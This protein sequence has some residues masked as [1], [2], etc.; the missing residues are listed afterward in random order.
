[1]RIDADVGADAQTRFE[2]P[3]GELERRAVSEVGARAPI[4]ERDLGQEPDP[5]RIRARAQA[6]T[7]EIGA[8]PVRLSE[9]GA[10]AG[11]ELGALPERE[12]RVA[13][14]E[15]QADIELDHRPGGGEV[16]PRDSLTREERPCRDPLSAD[17]SERKEP[18]GAHAGPERSARRH[19]TRLRRGR[20][21]P[22]E[23]RRVPRR[24]D[25]T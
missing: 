22:N 2:N 16:A 24:S 1:M 7:P 4:P 18:T 23:L 15:A 14:G 10:G 11:P 6:D 3:V 21:L 20:R 9:S 5:V 8:A 13:A 12:E 17:V 19:V 25:G